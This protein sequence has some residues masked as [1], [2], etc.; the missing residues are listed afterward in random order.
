VFF[1][2]VALL[3]AGIGLYGALDYLVLQRR[4]EIGIRMAIGAPAGDIA[5]RVTADIFLMV[6]VGA[7]AGITAGMAS[8]RYIQSLL[9]Q[10]K[11]GDPSMLLVPSAAI[12]GTALLAAVPAV[13]HAVRIDLV[14]MLR[15]E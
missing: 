1:A 4:R 7:A 10:V 11:L 6:L 14:S 5:R 9:Y 12:L 13:V 2:M 8:V 3:L 15:S